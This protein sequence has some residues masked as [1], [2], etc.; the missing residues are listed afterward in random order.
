MKTK[1]RTGAIIQG[2]VPEN[3]TVKDII[4]HVKKY[5]GSLN[6]IVRKKNQ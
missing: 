3:P 4:E 6:L 2:T 1:K 5:N